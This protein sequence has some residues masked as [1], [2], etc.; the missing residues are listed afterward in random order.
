MKRRS[1]IFSGFLLLMLAVTACAS[2]S[3]A[4][5]DP[6]SSD[7]VATIVAATVQA[8]PP[9]VT[10]EATPEPQESADLLPH[11][12]YYLGNDGAQL[13]Q[14]FRM[15][16]DGRTVTQ[17]TF[18]TDS[19]VSYDISLVDGIVAYVANNQLVM[20]EAD[21]SGRRV[22]VDGGPVDQN[23]PFLKSINSPVF[24]PDGKGLAYGLGGLNFYSLESGISN[25]VL[26]NQ[27]D[28]FGNGIIVP[29][30][31]FRPEKYSPDGQKLLITLGY[32]EGASSAI[33]YPNGNSLVRLK[34]DAGALI[35]CGDPNWSYDS[36]TL[37]SANPYMGMFMPGLW[38][39]DTSSGD[40]ITLLSG[41]AGNGN[42]NFASDAY[43]APDGQL[44]FFFANS[45]SEQDFGTR[46]PLQLVKSEPDGVTNRTVIRTETYE[47]MNE[48]LWSPD[49][50]FVLVAI[51]S[52]DS[53][54]AGGQ[55]EIVY[56]D[57]S[58]NVVLI[59][60]AQRLKWGP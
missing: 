45:K 60:F 37:Y 48:A 44:Y 22:L 26:E 27:L 33:Y 51:A 8:L 36:A 23:N 56:P 47:L 30:E 59:P 24:S 55:V 13:S 31:L 18:E 46:Q 25:L 12:L 35:C 34:N 53:I 15:E 29:R 19:V 16:K 11:N 42:F 57:G 41:D 50:R 14:I 32:Y 58:P 9:D 6:S 10:V 54:Y 3:D 17:L 7:Q 2:G 21:G 4:E 28:D 49:A 1:K 40:V 39:V 20:I 38:K 5:G 52:N 43:Y